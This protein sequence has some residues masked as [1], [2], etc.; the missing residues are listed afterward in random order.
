MDS[1]YNTENLAIDFTENLFKVGFKKKDFVI[2]TTV[3]KQLNYL[4][5]ISGEKI[6]IV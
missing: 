4:K 1:D 2:I 3:N 6:N 5:N